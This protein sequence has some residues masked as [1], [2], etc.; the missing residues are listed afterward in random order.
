MQQAKTMLQIGSHIAHTHCCA[1]LC[2]Y[3]T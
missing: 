1:V 3:G 2:L